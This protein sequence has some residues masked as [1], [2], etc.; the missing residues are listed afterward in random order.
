MAL[1]IPEEEL[2]LCFELAR[3]GYAALGLVNDLYSWSKEKKAAEDVGL[4]YVFN[5]IWVIMKE[6]S[7]SEEEAIM[8]CRKRVEDEMSTFNNNLVN[9]GVKQLSKDTV[10]YLEAVRYSYIGNLV[11]SIYCP[12]YHGGNAKTMRVN[13]DRIS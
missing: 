8:I 12:R 5:A 7:V 10:V 3:P 2:D 11:W 13:V 1:T 6:S 4:D 9:I